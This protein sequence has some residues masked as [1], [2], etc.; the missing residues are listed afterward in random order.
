VRRYRGHSLAFIAA[1]VWSLTSPGLKILLDDGAHPLALAFWRD[2]VIALFCCAGLLLFRPSLLRVTRK[3]LLQFG[4]TGAISIGIYHAIWVYSIALNGAA[5][6]IVMIYMFPTFV[7]IGS[8]LLFREPLRWTQVVALAVSL[9]GCALLV[10]LID[11]LQTG[12]SAAIR[13]SWFGILIGLL[14]ALTHTVYVLFS[15]RSVQSRSPWTSLTYTMVFGSLTLLLLLGGITLWGALS[16]QPAQPASTGVFYLGEHDGKQWL[17]WLIL[18]GIALG[19]TLGGY[20]L[21]T[22]TLQH[23][24]GRIASLIVVVEAPIASL[25]AFWLVGE[26]LEWPQL[27]GM[28]LILGAIV[29]PSA[30]DRLTL[31]QSAEVVVG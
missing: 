6:A 12:G 22:A 2:A 20:G 16:G 21:F 11:P 19:P 14:T 30:L 27:L 28:A 15:Q 31:R 5:V 3:E 17:A 7:S 23:L 24:P 26:R 29:L 13:F 8:W 4:L 10:R 18:I 9:L 25:L 1:I